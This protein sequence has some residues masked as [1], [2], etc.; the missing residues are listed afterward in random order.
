MSYKVLIIGN[1]F[2]INIDKN[3]KNYQY[4]LYNYYKEFNKSD[5]LLDFISQINYIDFKNINYDFFNKNETI[6]YET[7]N[8]ILKRK[9]RFL[10]GIELFFNK[11]LKK[12]DS[13]Y[14]KNEVDAIELFLQLTYYEFIRNKYGE[15]INTFFS[16]IE[17]KSL[18]TKY[19]LLATTN[20]TDSL[21]LLK[22][23]LIDKTP[24]QKSNFFYPIHSENLYVNGKINNTQMISGKFPNP[25]IILNRKK[26]NKDFKNRILYKAKKFKHE[27]IIFDF[28][29]ISLKNDEHIIKMIN[30]INN[31]ENIRIIINYY[32]YYRKDTKLL[33]K[34]KYLKKIELNFY[35][36]KEWE[37][38]NNLFSSY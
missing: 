10:N 1:G 22:E 3:I 12:F 35:S 4:D 32:Y 6:I 18:N 28:F 31:N 34:C 5:V 26:I 15:K 16:K 23:K 27:I 11:L 25:Q 19:H 30:E 2:D 20:F 33:K 38:Y 14:K 7:I 8:Y 37:N 21:L 29:G 9:R 36:Y 17:D 24:E 13:K